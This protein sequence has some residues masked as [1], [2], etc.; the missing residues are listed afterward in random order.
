MPEAQAAERSS[1]SLRPLSLYLGNCMP[2]RYPT[3]VEMWTKGPSL[4]KHMPVATAKT[5]PNALTART[6][7][8]GKWGITKRDNIVLISGMP[9]PAAIYI[10]LPVVTGADAVTISMPLNLSPLVSG[11]AGKE[12]FVS[13]VAL[14]LIMPKAKAQ[15]TYIAKDAQ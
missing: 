8:S 9:D 13:M 14:E 15:A 4:P 2:T 6:L 11:T 10:F 12:V 1:L 3:Q 5:A 7:R